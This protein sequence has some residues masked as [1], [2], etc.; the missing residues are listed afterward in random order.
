M[1]PCTPSGAVPRTLEGAEEALDDAVGL[2]LGDEGEARGDAPEPDLLLEVLGHEGGT[3]VMAQREAAGGAGAKSA[4]M[5]ADRHG[6]GLG[7][8]EARA[9]LADMPA[10]EF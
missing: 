8:F 3:M 5:L 10:E 7:G 9:D 1:R 4:A 6:D 2:R